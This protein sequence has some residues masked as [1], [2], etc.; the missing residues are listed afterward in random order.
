MAASF[1]FLSLFVCCCCCLFLTLI[2]SE[3]TTNIS[4]PIFWLSTFEGL[5]S[6]FKQLEEL[7][8]LTKYTNVI[9]D[10]RPI[11]A[12][13]FMVH[14]HFPDMHHEIRICDFFELPAR[15]S[16]GGNSTLKELIN[17]Y[18]NQS[19][20][21]IK[22]N[23]LTNVGKLTVTKV[24]YYNNITCIGGYIPSS[25]KLSFNGGDELQGCIRTN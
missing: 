14:S 11:I 9:S 15:I 17:L 21:A 6:H 20:C 1:Q 13:P 24:I 10:G 19:T 22:S 3:E 16:C 7:Y 8:Y 2:K 18:Y 25:Q 12:A 4:S 5:A 23:G